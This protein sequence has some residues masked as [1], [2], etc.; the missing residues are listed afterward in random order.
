M[1]KG[2]NKVVQSNAAEKLQDWIE[3]MSNQSNACLEKM[4]NNPLLI[5]GDC[6]DEAPEDNHEIPD[7]VD[8]DYHDVDNSMVDTAL[9]SGTVR[10]TNKDTF[11]GHFSPDMTRR[12]GTCQ[13]NLKFNCLGTTGTWNSGLLDGMAVLENA[14]G[15][16]EET[17]FKRGVKH[18]YSRKF[19]PQPKK[20]GNLWQVALY[21]NGKMHGHFWRGC[22]GGGYITGVSDD[23]D[24][25]GDNI[26]YI[27]PNLKDGILGK[28]ENGKFLSGI[29]VELSNVEIH[30]GMAIGSFTSIPTASNLLRDRST[31]YRI[32]LNP[33]V[34]DTHEHARVEARLSNTPDSGEG[35]FAKTEFKEDDLVSILNGIRVS[36]SIQDEWSDYKVNFNTELD[37]DVPADMRRLDQYCATLAHKANHSFTPNT[38]WGRLD[39]P[40]FG[41]VVTIIAIKTIQVGEELTVN[42]KYPVTIAPQWYKDCHKLFYKDNFVHKIY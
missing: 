1:G 29:E 11:K 18:G 27:F 28:F 31:C 13:K 9:K 25:T 17:Y 22:L 5:N 15:G 20:K 4:Q 14:Y 38:R 3:K 23:N 30:N 36:P 24:I 37:L 35:L 34:P 42:Y 40:R 19:G 21:K 6:N 12:I 8:I 2:E 26:A 41:L 33:L 10:F 16:Y 32:A 39:H 7:V